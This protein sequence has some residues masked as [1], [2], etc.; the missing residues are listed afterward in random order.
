MGNQ[1][2]STDEEEQTNTTNLA[3]T[4]ETSPTP[5]SPDNDLETPLL[6]QPTDQGQDNTAIAGLDTQDN[7]NDNEHNQKEKEGEVEVETKEELTLQD[8]LNRIKESYVSFSVGLV[9]FIGSICLLT[10]NRINSSQ[11]KE[12]ISHAVHST[13]QI[14][15]SPNVTAV[16]SELDGEVVYFNTS[17]GLTD[18]ALLTDPDFGVTTPT[19]GMMLERYGSM[20]QWVEHLDEQKNTYSYTK[21]WRP[22][23][24]NS[25]A[26][27]DDDTHQNPDSLAFED[28]ELLVH[29]PIMVGVYEMPEQIVYAPIYTY[30]KIT[31][32]T[33]D[34]IPSENTALK[35][36]TILHD[37][38]L[39]ISS[40]LAGGEEED[41]QKT[42]DPSNP[43][44]GDTKVFFRY[45][46]APVDISVVARQT[47]NTFDYIDVE[48]G[49]IFV[50]AEVSLTEI[51]ME[52]YLPKGVNFGALVKLFYIV[53]FCGFALGGYLILKPLNYHNF[54]LAF[55]IL[56]IFMIFI[57]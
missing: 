13:K 55:I 38:G 6:S 7:D 53:G 52:Y 17:L 11:M 18:G 40:G 34:D 9:L 46:P 57:D 29:D 16:D 25:S 31:N 39:Y 14:E 5:P 22:Y 3:F 20:Y 35:E 41:K 50:E 48:N 24:V 1:V 26:F 49:L 45:I 15:V 2:T 37:G 19:N 47:G 27:H 33:L 28:Y 36:N 42:V 21:E 56:G 44:V 12:K 54:V 51:M 10:W 30:D 23:W 4:E 8:C 32:L 43:Q